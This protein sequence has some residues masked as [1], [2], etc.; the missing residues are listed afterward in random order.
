VIAKGPSDATVAA[1]AA[2]YMR[3]EAER[4]AREEAERV[5]REAA[6][7]GSPVVVE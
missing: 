2:A 4:I 6:A 3:E 1:E 7:S 5:A